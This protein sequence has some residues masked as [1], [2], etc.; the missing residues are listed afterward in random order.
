M[1]VIK[2]IEIIASSPKRWEDA[3]KIAV[4][5]AG[6]KSKRN[7]LRLYSSHKVNQ[8]LT[9]LNCECLFF[10]ARFEPGFG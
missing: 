2:V 5:T 10:C 7:T 3:T 4:K 9:V 8:T 1:A 6:E